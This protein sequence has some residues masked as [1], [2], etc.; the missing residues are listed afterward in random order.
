MQAAVDGSSRLFT[1]LS[2]RVRL[3]VERRL[4]LRSAAGVRSF[5]FYFNHKGKIPKVA[6]P[7]LQ[8]CWVTVY[9]FSMTGEQTKPQRVNWKQILDWDQRVSSRLRLDEGGGKN[10]RLAAL[11]AHS[12]DSWF[13]L[14]ALGLVW[15]F[16]QGEWHTRSALLAIAVFSLAVLVMGI[17]FTVKRSRPPGE[18]GSVYRLTDP[19][20]F[21]S[22]HAARAFLLMMLVWNLGPVWLALA[23]TIWA[24]LVSL[25]R[26]STGMHY[27]SDVLGGA[28]IGLAAGQLF[29]LSTPLLL[30]LFPFLF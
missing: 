10:L 8:K 29:F 18:W 25:A 30:S 2:F 4:A 23:L 15:L 19:H 11:L 13:W 12:G 24:P 26:V 3:G 27:M 21:P 14:P 6:R 28:L 17:K 1:F 7:T 22:G 5:L 16:T 9:S 20:S